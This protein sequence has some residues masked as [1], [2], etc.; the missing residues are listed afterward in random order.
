MVL[1]VSQVGLG[2]ILLRAS[3]QLG[4]V[5]GFGQGPPSRGARG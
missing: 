4:Q 3:A 2:Q 1:A 5:G